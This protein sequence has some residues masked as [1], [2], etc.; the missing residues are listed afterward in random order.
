MNYMTLSE[1]IDHAEQIINDTIRDEGFTTIKTE[2]GNAV[3]IT[4]H[5]FEC[6][7]E[8]LIRKDPHAL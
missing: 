6:L 4:E 5:Q 7:M 8:A 2:T 3:L 1:F